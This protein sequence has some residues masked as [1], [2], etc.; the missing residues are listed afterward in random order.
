MQRSSIHAD[1]RFRLILAPQHQQVPQHRQRPALRRRRLPPLPRMQSR[2][3]PSTFSRL[4]VMLGCFSR[5]LR[6]LSN[7]WGGSARRP[8]AVRIPQHQRAR[9]HRRAPVQCVSS[10]SVPSQHA[11][12]R[13]AVMLKSVFLCVSTMKP[14]KFGLKT[15]NIAVVK[16]AANSLEIVASISSK[17]GAQIHW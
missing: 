15:R 8:T 2:A 14:A 10:Q 7:V 5:L 17:V 9:Q 4:A 16:A 12:P 13:H 3:D 1:S 11:V 6:Q